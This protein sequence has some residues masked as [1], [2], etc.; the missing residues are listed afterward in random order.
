MFEVRQHESPNEEC[1]HFKLDLVQ[2]QLNEPEYDCIN[3]HAMILSDK[4]IS[5]K[6]HHLV[7]EWI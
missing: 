5:L 2:L 7:H 6:W 3:E 4:P 1:L